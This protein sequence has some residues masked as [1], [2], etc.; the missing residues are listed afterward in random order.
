MV[1][2]AYVFSRPNEVVGIRFANTT[3]RV[4][5]ADNMSKQIKGLMFR[6]SLLDSTGMLFTFDK[7]DYS[8][9]M[10]NMRFSI[11]V[12]WFDSEGKVVDFIKNVQP[13]SLYCP[14]HKP[15]EMASYILE[16]NSGF[17]ENQNVG[18]G[19]HFQFVV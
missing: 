18:I 14:Y 8:I 7:E 12:V 10:I 19:D 11:D 1:G 9:W 16:V 13:C 2:L 6:D 17:I 3:I 5:L 15:T 4:E